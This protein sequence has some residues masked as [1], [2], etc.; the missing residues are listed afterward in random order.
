MRIAFVV[1]VSLVLSSP[2]WAAEPAAPPRAARSVQ[3]G[4]R[5]PDAVLL[6][7]EMTV[8]EST[9]GSYFM[10]AAWNTGH[11]GIQELPDGRQVR[12]G[13]HTIPWRRPGCGT[14]E[15]HRDARSL[16]EGDGLRWLT[17]V[18]ETE[19]MADLDRGRNDSCWL[20][21]DDAK[22]ADDLRRVQAEWKTRTPTIVPWSWRDSQFVSKHG[23]AAWQGRLLLVG[24][25]IFSVRIANQACDQGSANQ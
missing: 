22:R 15:A 10:A 5:V 18:P 21:A 11:F 1:I 25:A 23:L 9:P 6:Y 8:L 19:R 20:A 3:L 7:N 17:F 16:W 12:Q 13:D 4:Y 2:N 14:G 24:I